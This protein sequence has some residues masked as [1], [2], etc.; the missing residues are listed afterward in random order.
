[1]S[2]LCLGRRYLKFKPSPSSDP[3]KLTLSSSDPLKLTLFSKTVPVPL[4]LTLYRCSSHFLR[5]QKIDD[6]GEGEE[7]AEGADGDEEEGEE[8]DDDDDD[9]DDDGGGGGGGGGHIVYE[10]TG[11]RAM[12]AL[13]KSITDEY[14]RGR[15]PY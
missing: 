2:C 4:K 8:G 9:D 15:L 3:L 1:M 10:P 11:D 14:G 6:D 5:W 13:H 7:E 12:E